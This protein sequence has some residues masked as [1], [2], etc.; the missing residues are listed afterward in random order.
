MAVLNGTPA[1]VGRGTHT[2]T[3]RVNGGTAQLQY[4]VD[5]LAMADLPESTYTADAD[6]NKSIP[7]CK[8]Q[9][10]LTGGATVNINLVSDGYN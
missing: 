4:S 7:A 3:V 6:E 1:D 10:V 9:A 2:V 5:G 8:M